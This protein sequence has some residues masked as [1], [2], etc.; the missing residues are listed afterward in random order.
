MRLSRQ[1]QVSYNEISKLAPVTLFQHKSA[2]MFVR[3]SLH[4]TTTEND[5]SHEECFNQDDVARDESA[6][7]APVDQEGVDASGQE[8]LQVGVQQPAKK[9]RRN[10]VRTT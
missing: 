3:P 6:N 9:P 7:N 10:P 2:K 4:H 8:E 5:G 1:T